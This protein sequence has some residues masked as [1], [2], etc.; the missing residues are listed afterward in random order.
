[1]KTALRLLLA[2][3]LFTG[4]A[5]LAEAQT[6]EITHNTWTSGAPMPTALF[7]P[8]VGV[9]K[10]QIYVVGGYNGG[11]LSGTQ[12]YNPVTNAW[13]TGV[14]LPVAT[15]GASGAVVKNIM[16]VIGGSNDGSQTQTNAVWAYNPK[17][18]TWSSRAAMP[19]A[20]QDA[21]LAVEK[22]II[23]VIGGYNKNAGGYLTTV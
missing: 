23:Y 13:S 16:Y 19:T 18:K 22:N 17:T 14:S 3:L 15:N 2:S 20:R 12:I 8:V 1:M 5:S 9:L 7:Q 6:P 10:G 4:T 11:P 21:G